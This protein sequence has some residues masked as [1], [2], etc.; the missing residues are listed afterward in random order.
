MM[1]LLIIVVL[2][3]ACIGVVTTWLFAELVVEEL[4]E[5]IEQFA[6]FCEAYQTHRVIREAKADIARI[7]RKAEIVIQAE[8]KKTTNQQ[9]V[10]HKGTRP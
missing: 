5:E 2:A 4:Q 3:F 10:R 8:T 9:A 1:T 6:E 7:E